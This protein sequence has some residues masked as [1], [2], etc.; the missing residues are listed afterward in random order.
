MNDVRST[1]S[2]NGTWKIAFD[3]ENVG[4]EQTWQSD[5]P[6]HQAEDL[7]V[8]GV[9]EQ[10]RPGYD[11]VAWYRRE[12]EADDAWRGK[13]VRLH[14]GACFYY[15]ERGHN[16]TY[17]GANEGGFLPFEFE[18]ADKLKTGAN[19][20]VMRVIGPPADRE[21]EGLRGGA[22]LNQSDL[23]SSKSAWYY[24]FGGIWQDVELRVTDKLRIDDIF[25][26]PRPADACADVEVTVRNEKS[27]GKVELALR[28][29]PDD[30]GE[31]AASLEQTLDLEE[32]INHTTVTV[33]FDSFTHWSPEN[34]FLYAAEATLLQDETAVDRCR[35]RFGMREFTIR[36]GHF[37]LNGEPIVL[38]G[39]LQQGM[40]PRTLIFPE[41]PDIARR[42]LELMKENGFNF[43]R[44]HLKPV[45]QVLDMAD[46]M[47][48]L[49]E[50]E[51]PLGWISNSPQL[52]WKAKP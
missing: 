6:L 16:G 42:E 15:T 35:E 43:L 46:E 19:T 22:P 34:P 41:T 4:K 18:L 2:L 14:V 21:I 31:A 8:P 7:K 40:Y 29:V 48:I 24:N 50:A 9:W 32:G 1:L 52:P 33:A 11:G 10:I 25:V 38:K 37:V 20:V 3:P 27:P 30:G 44:A 45:S 23:P 28:I 39:F 49:I 13:S 36:D 26:K 17:L 51:P 5:F 47:G 12:F